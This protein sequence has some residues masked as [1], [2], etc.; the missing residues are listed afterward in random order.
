[1]IKQYKASRGTVRLAIDVL[2]N[3]G[4]LET[5]QGRGTVVKPPYK[6]RRLTTW[7]YQEELDQFAAGKPVRPEFTQV[8]LDFLDVEAAPVL[9]DL[10]HIPA[11]TPLLRRTVRYLEHDEPL[12]LNTTY[13]LKELVDGTPAAERERE[14][15]P[16]EF[17][18]LHALGV[19]PTSVRE[20]SVARMPTPQEANALKL[21]QGTPVTAFTR[22]VFAGDDVV[23][24]SLPILY[25]GDRYRFETHIE[26]TGPTE[27]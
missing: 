7:R 26:L 27:A 14:P 4:L 25:P 16:G 5:H 22:Q 13:H 23:E 8:D 3:D 21:R 11:G 18:V 1:L 12:R 10:F 24:V 9:A 2:R 6:V 17:G 19:V 15:W 20:S